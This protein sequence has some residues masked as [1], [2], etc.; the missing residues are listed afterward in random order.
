[1]QRQWP[2]IGRFIYLFWDNFPVC[3]IVMLSY[4]LV[5]FVKYAST[6]VLFRLFRYLKLFECF[7]LDVNVFFFKYPGSHIL[8]NARARCEPHA[9]NFLYSTTT[10]IHFLHHG[11]IAGRI[12]RSHYGSYCLLPCFYYHFASLSR[13]SLIASAVLVPSI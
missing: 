3:L 12:F 13:H 11:G 8:W 5:K 6:Y 7:E 9:G 2:T 10:G 1:M 4:I